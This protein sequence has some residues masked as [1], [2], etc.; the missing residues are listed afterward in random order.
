MGYFLYYCLP[1]RRK[2]VRQNI[3]LVFQQTLSI[4]EKKR[5]ALAFYSHLAMIIKEVF[6]LF[7]FQSITQLERKVE[8]RGAEYLLQAAELQKGV[9]MLTGHLGNWEC[10]P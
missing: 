3:D 6:F 9:L 5:L 1:I 8:V 4:R 2:V 7:S 10:T